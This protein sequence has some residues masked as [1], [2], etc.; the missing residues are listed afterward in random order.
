MRCILFA[1]GLVLTATPAFAY[2]PQSQKAW[3]DDIK[4]QS[5]AYVS[6]GPCEDVGFRTDQTVAEARLKA[7]FSSASSSGVTPVYA[8]SYASLQLNAAMTQME[9][10]YTTVGVSDDPASGY[11]WKS[12]IFTYWS[13][14]CAR[15]AKGG[16]GIAP[17]AFQKSGHPATYIGYLEYKAEQGAPYDM[18]LLGATYG[19]GLA[20]DPGG[21]KELKWTTLAAD[22][23]SGYAAYRL[24]MINARGELGQPKNTV[25]AMVW[26]II[27]DALGQEDKIELKPDLLKVVTKSELARSGVE[28]K[29]WLASH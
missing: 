12:E 21:V 7:T 13:P 19:L 3:E 2:S 24:A 10:H 1:T 16:N 18:A 23:R 15:L 8:N 17:G 26:L 11:Q 25:Q 9:A 27:A 20:P 5:E 28:A 22:K 4:A 29:A 14:V 6:V